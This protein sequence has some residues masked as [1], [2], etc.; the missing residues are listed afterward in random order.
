MARDQLIRTEGT[1]NSDTIVN[2]NTS[3]YLVLWLDICIY[4]RDFRTFLMDS[5][6]LS[7]AE[8]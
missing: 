6:M 7:E 3:V 4:K 8:T 2:L 5:L 1:S